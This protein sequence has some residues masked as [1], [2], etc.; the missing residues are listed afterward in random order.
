MENLGLNLQSFVINTLVFLA[1]FILMH[2]LVLKKIGRLIAEREARILE[3]DKRAEETK[4]ALANAQ[5]EFDRI[6]EDAKKEAQKIADDSKSMADEQTKKILEKAQLDA[7]EIIE[8]AQS[9]LAV[10]KERMLADFKASMEKSVKSALT[11]ILASQADRI[12][13][14]ADMLKEESIE[15]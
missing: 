15:S 8:K 7:E 6:V 11:D 14:D 9:V 5:K 12:D 10:E 1:F 2:F 3:T 4:V 13:F